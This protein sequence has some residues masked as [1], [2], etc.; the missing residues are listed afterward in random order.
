MAAS[1]GRGAGRWTLRAVHTPGH[2]S[3]HHCYA[4]A[5]QSVLFTGDH[6]MGW[7]TSVISPPDGDMAAYVESLR[8]VAGRAD[9]RLW[10]THGPAVDHPR[11][12]VEALVAHRLDREAQIVAV[13]RAGPTGIPEIVAALYADVDPGLHK[14]AA[15][16]VLA[17]L[18][19][20]VDDGVVATVDGTRAGSASRYVAV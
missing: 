6:V 20:L 10:P 7:S 3:N 4:L 5:E 13:V 19:K 16:S 14:A 17:H 11:P 18:R 2:T 8:K 1:G 9:A 12:Y 15:R